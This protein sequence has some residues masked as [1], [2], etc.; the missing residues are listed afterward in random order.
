[1]LNRLIASAIYGKEKAVVAGAATG[2]L[3]LLAL[4]GVSGDM[5]VKEVVTAA[6]NWIVAHA[7]VYFVSNRPKV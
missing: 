7:L 4:V 2:I 6:A 3:S 1:M 5:T